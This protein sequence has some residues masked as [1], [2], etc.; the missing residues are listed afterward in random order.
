MC[1]HL[2][3]YNVILTQNG[4]KPMYCRWL[5]QVTK[6]YNYIHKYG[7]KSKLM[8]AAVR[9]KQ[10]LFSLLG[11]HMTWFLSILMGNHYKLRIKY[12]L[13]LNL[14][15]CLFLSG[16]TIS[17]HPWRCYN[18]S[19]NQLLFLMRSTLMWGGCPRSLLPPTISLLRRSAFFSYFFQL[20]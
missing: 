6:A 10:D 20:T 13:F 14:W 9:N 11:Y 12:F 5:L 18:H 7:H 3:I 16:L 15:Y 19:K 2:I 4:L 17:L 8:A 1:L